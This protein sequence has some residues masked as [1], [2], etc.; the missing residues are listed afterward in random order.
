LFSIKEI[1]TDL[2]DIKIDNNKDSH[3]KI[4]CEESVARIFA[5]SENIFFSGE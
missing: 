3:K 4:F 1:L 2:R 5:Q